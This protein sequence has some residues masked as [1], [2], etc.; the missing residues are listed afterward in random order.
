MRLVPHG[1]IEIFHPS[2]EPSGF[3]PHAAECPDGIPESGA[4]ILGT[5]AALRNLRPFSMRRIH[6]SLGMPLSPALPQ[7]SSV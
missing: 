3:A 5:A 6:L 4:G 7:K 1:A 2:N